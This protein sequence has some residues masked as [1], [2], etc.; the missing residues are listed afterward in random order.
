MK[1][2]VPALFALGAVV[3]AAPALAGVQRTVLMEEFGF[4]T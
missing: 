4:A 2:L 1:S 3:F